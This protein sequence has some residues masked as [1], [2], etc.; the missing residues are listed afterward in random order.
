METCCCC[1]CCATCFGLTAEVGVAI[2]QRQQRRVQWVVAVAQNGVPPTD[3]LHY[4]WV[5]A[6]LLQTRRGNA[7]TAS[8]K[9]GAC[10]DIQRHF[11]LFDQ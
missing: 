4:L 11:A 1:C 8:G 9:P 3:L 7:L 2:R 5:Q 6:V 10:W